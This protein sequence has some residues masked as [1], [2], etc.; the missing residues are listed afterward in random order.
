MLFWSVQS[1]WLFLG[2]ERTS[3]DFYLF[4]H[5]FLVFS[6]VFVMEKS[7]PSNYFPSN[8]IFLLTETNTF[9]K[10]VLINCTSRPRRSYST[11]L[12]RPDLMFPKVYVDPLLVELLIQLY[13][14][15]KTANVIN[16]QAFSSL[17]SLMK[18]SEQK[19]SFVFCFNE[20]DSSTIL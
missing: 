11:S 9:S 3:N 20:G 8:T 6:F 17:V 12:N 4:N 16:I 5:L 7:K 10:S 15:I 13:R 19:R 2:D 1:F 18:C 14:Q